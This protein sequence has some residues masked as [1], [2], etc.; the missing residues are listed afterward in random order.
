MSSEYSFTHR[1]LY[2]SPIRISPGDA[3]FGRRENLSDG[4]HRPILRQTFSFSLPGSPDIRFGLRHPDLGTAWVRRR[5]RSLGAPTPL[6]AGGS[7]HPPEPR[8]RRDAGRPGRGRPE[9]IRHHGHRRIKATTE[10]SREALRMSRSCDSRP[11]SAPDTSW[12]PRGRVASISFSR[13]WQA[14]AA[15]FGG[16]AR[17]VPHQ[18]HQDRHPLPGRLFERTVQETRLFSVC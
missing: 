11:D 15:G 4:A 16:R 12:P 2:K 9:G 10:R 17:P 8:A 14:E 7:G 6:A 5:S 1:T 13:E 18:H 3:F